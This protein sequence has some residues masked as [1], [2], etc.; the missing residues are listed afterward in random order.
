LAAVAGGLLAP[1]AVDE[2]LRRDR[3]PFVEGEHRKQR[4]WLAG[5]DGDRPTVDARLQRTYDLNVHLDGTRV[6]WSDPTPGT[7]RGKPRSRARGD[8]D[9]GRAVS[10]SR[11][12]MKESPVTGSSGWMISVTV[13]VVIAAGLAWRSPVRKRRQA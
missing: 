4:P 13:G 3:R 10:V 11:S 5:A 7:R 9:A 2:P 8:P 6:P 1:Q 12:A